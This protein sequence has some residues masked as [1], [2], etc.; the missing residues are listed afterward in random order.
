MLLGSSKTAKTVEFTVQQL[1][2]QHGFQDAEQ[3]QRLVRARD[4][5]ERLSTH[6][7]ELSCLS[8]FTSLAVVCTAPLWKEV[9]VSRGNVVSCIGRHLLAQEQRVRVV[10]FELEWRFPRWTFG[11]S[12]RDSDTSQTVER[13]GIAEVSTVVSLQLTF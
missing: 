13:Q 5:P 8:P 10:H 6:N 11:L 12:L 9:C 2:W 7:D 3:R 1:E 4:D